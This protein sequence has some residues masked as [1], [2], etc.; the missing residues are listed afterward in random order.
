MI[1]K[2]ADFLFE[3]SWEVCNKVGGIYTV[4]KSKIRPTSKYYGQDYYVIGPH[5][6]DKATGEFQEMIPPVGIRDV[7]SKLKDRGI[8][9]YYGAW[10]VPGEPQT[11]LVD[12]TGYAKN[13]NEIKKELWDKYRID[14]LGTQYHDFDEP[15]VWAYTVGILLEEIAKLSDKKIVAHFHEWLSGAGLLY[16]KS[17]NV[18]IGTVFTTHATMLGRTI[19]GN[20][21]DLYGMMNQIDPIQ[22]ANELQVKSKYQMETQC[23][24]HADVFST[25]SEITGLEAEALLGK[26]PDILL[27]NGLDIDKFP[28]FEEASIKH[29]LFRG[30]I[31]DFLMYYFFPYYTFDLDKTLI[32]F[33]AGRYEYHDKGVDTFIMA[34][35]R[36]NE[37]M[38]KDNTDTT[39]VAFF[40]IPGN[41]RGIKPEIVEN[42]SLFE[43]V[44]DSVDD[45]IRDIRERVLYALMAGHKMS[46]EFLLDADVL[47]STKKRILRIKKSGNPPVSTHD[48]YNE[49]QDLIITNLKN[50]NLL[51]KQEDKVKV[52]F[53]PIY[54]TGADRL[55][56][57]TYYESMQ[58]SHLG[59]F[60][61]YYEPWGYTP[62]E[63]GALGVASVTTDL[64]GFG[65][66]I[67]SKIGVTSLPGIFVL[68]RFN[69]SDDEAV[70]QLTKIMFDY[71]KFT[72]QE[73]IEN[74]IQAMKLA[75]LADWKILIEN[76]I[77]A[78]NLAV[79]KTW[80]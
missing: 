63:A 65:R 54:L 48:L 44:K 10:L 77:R 11:I 66:Y 4:V 3:V 29:H 64:A 21:L 6:V 42:K 76:Y 39:V 45:S 17:R 78:H 46:D 1:K 41:I 71:T 31:R 69:K 33:I 67:K 52:V 30:K 20:G 23:A 7:F 28:T 14:S 26:K 62:L 80:S 73:R 35:S 79:E 50:F 47:Q 68:D 22:M 72:R 8:I 40:W 32:F 37:L 74:K 25:V 60:A 34:L 24:R 19:A 57:T 13:A 27:P 49:D 38:K 12:F 2:E 53:Y 75:A 58:G 51:N 55:L 56:D 9:C 15:V 16:L 43:D 59:V 70:T 18:R 36:L 61:S 5:F